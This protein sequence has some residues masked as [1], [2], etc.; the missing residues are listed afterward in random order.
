MQKILFVALSL[1]LTNLALACGGKPCDGCD[2][3]HAEATET[4]VDVSKA[5]GTQLA[6]A[7]TGMH[8]GKCSSKITVALTNVDGVNAASV[9][10]EKGT[11]QI[12]YDAKKTNPE[13]LIKA[14]AAVGD[15]EAKQ[16]VSKEG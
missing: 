1:G 3:A 5:D 13:A 8:C 14:I 7:V 11:A 4:A 2:K 9:D 6:L 10:H 15:F 12:A 16:I